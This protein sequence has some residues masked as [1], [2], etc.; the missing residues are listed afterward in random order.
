MNT[1][2]R[3]DFLFELI[4][5]KVLERYIGTSSQLIWL[6]VSPIIPLVLNLLVFFY[7]AKMPA[8]ISMG[9]INY[10]IYIFTGLL[11]FRFIQK[12][13]S[14]GCDLLVANL[15]MLKTANFPLNFLSLTAVGASLADL[16][17][18]IVL[19]LI[20]IFFL[21][22]PLSSKIFL[23]PIALIFLAMLAIGLSWLLSIGGY[24]L[25]DFQEVISV[26]FTAL[27]FCTPI[28][29]PTSSAPEFI[30]NIMRLNP[31]TYYVEIFR[32]VFSVDISVSYISW[33]IT[34]IISVLIFI[35]G[36]IAINKARTFA[37][38]MI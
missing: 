27:L 26:F 12:A 3:V 13:T 6:F 11:P 28:L 31:A 10:I 35:G 36:F 21:G 37:G 8:A 38:D 23:L 15:E 7:I 33:V 19:L 22:H 17:V 16:F 20:L 30:V 32:D 9:E 29:Y 4:R 5:R 34:F 18:Q 24:I 14:D 1:N 25:R 2:I